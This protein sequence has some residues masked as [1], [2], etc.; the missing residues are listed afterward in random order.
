MKKQNFLTMTILVVLIGLVSC[1]GSY[2]AKTPKLATQED[3]L[4]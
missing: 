4:N 2:K 3:S 1:G